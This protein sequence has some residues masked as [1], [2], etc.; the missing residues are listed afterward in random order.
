MRDL[1]AAR[2]HAKF[3]MISFFIFY[4]IY[5]DATIEINTIT[6]RIFSIID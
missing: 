4:V 1:I 5:D 2:E 6:P 3:S